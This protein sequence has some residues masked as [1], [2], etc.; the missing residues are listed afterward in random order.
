[1]ASQVKSIEEIGEKGIG[2]KSV[3]SVAKRVE[4]FSGGFNFALS[5]KEPT[6][7]EVLNGTQTIDNGTFMRFKMKI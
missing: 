6:V 7:P 3:F 1:M 5:D 2:F 4:I